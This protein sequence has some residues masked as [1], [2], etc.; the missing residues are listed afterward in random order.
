MTTFNTKFDTFISHF[1]QHDFLLFQ[2]FPNL[3]HSCTKFIKID[4]FLPTII[5]TINFSPIHHLLPDLTIFTKQTNFSCSNA[6]NPV[7]AVT[8]SS[9]AKFLNFVLPGLEKLQLTKVTFGSIKGCK[10]RKTSLGKN[11]RGANVIKLFTAVIYK[12]C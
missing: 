2:N 12:F 6:R 8:P 10:R 9:I 3:T 5:Q 11:R 1:I 4:T 7:K